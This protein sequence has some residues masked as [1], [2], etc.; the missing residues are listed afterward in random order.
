MKPGGGLMGGE[1]K[2]RR[3]AASSLLDRAAALLPNGQSTR[4]SLPADLRFVPEHAAGAMLYDTEGRG[5]VDYHGGAGALILGHS[6]PAV[7]AAAQVQ[8][9]KG[10]VFFGATALP[11]LLLAEELVKAIPCAE[12]I[13]FATTGSEATAYALRLARSATGRSRVLKFDEAYHGNQDWSQAVFDPAANDDSGAPATR[14]IPAEVARLVLVTPFNDLPAARRV[15]ADHGAEIA[16]IIVEPVQRAIFAT[17]EFL[18]GL[19]RL[20]DES[21]AVLIFDEVVTG[22]RLAYGG[23]QEYFGVVPDLACYGKIIGGGF[24]L[25][26][27]AGRADLLDRCGGD[28]RNAADYALVNGTHHGSAVAAAAGL[29]TLHALT[30]PRFYTDL[31]AWTFDLRRE[32]NDV[33][34]RRGSGARLFGGASMWQMTFLD[35]EPSSIEDLRN[36]DYA[37][38][39]AFD[40]CLVA[41]GIFVLEGNRRLASSAHGAEELELTVKAFDSACRLIER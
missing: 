33:L 9:A 30:Q 41:H 15:V 23:A 18:A 17:P 29:A 24:P 1:I 19:R 10:N 20:A 40:R 6:P 25:S 16:A 36:D 39:A 37:T 32:A 12:K 4:S 13:V 27:V 31:A 8:M 26:A 5:F 38:L 3:P 7:V 35:R 34:R 22:F 28:R 14:S 21:G 2:T 11:T